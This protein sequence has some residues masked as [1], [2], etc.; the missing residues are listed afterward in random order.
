MN[1]PKVTEIKRVLEP[2]TRDTFN[3]SA[4][5]PKGKR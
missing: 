5:A 2:T 1:I 4:K 3:D